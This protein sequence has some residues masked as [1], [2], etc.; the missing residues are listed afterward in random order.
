VNFT[1][2]LSPQRITTV[3]S[4]GVLFFAALGLPIQVARYGFNY[5]ERWLTLFNLDKELNYPTWFSAFMLLFC[6]I[7]LAIIAAAKKKERDRYANN[8]KILSIIFVF[9]SLDEV[10]SVHE[11]FIINDLRKAL[12][13]GG[14]F[15]FIWVI[16]AVILLV[17]FSLS[18]LRFLRNLPQHTQYLFI[19]AACI[20][21]G[22]ALGMEMISGYYA[23]LYGQRNLVYG[24]IASVEEL[25]EMIGII[26]FIYALLAYI[27]F[28]M[29][30]FSV[31]FSISSA[32]KH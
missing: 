21:V 19:Q 25:T 6:A 18:Y 3:L 20:Y 10:I 30:D 23:D 27:R 7:L 13:L 5:Q 32:Q 17:I 16:P 26:A 22:G 2:S 28:Y 31:R 12:N 15:Y 1:I 8:W 4:L 9:L 11:I 24:L 14:V 29:K